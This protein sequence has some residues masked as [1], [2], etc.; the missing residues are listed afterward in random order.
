[1][2]VRRADSPDSE[3]LPVRGRLT[4]P[5]VFTPAADSDP[6]SVLISRALA[7]ALDAA[8]QITTNELRIP[9]DF[10]NP[11]HR[12]LWFLCTRWPFFYRPPR[13]RALPWG[14]SAF[15]TCTL[16]V[17]DP[18]PGDE[19]ADWSQHWIFGPPPGF[20]PSG[21][22]SRLYREITNGG[23]LGL[24]RDVLTGLQGLE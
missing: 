23:T 10:T 7:S 12:D 8:Q 21:E 22:A 16:P 18:T 2:R 24:L 13:Q 17:W 14:N 15:T 20:T 4:T 9:L 3:W 5:I 1:M 6:D 11:A 19:S